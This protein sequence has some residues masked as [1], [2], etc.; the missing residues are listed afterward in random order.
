MAV[1][2]FHTLIARNKRNSFFLIAL[3]MLFFVGMG[4]LIGYVWGRD[5]LFGSVVAGIA[6]AVA[7][8]LTITSYF[9]GS[10]ALLGLSPGEAFRRPGGAGSRQSGHSATLHRPPDKKLREASGRDLQ[11]APERAGPDQTPDVAGD[12]TGQK[13]P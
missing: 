13:L 1:E 3:F 10:S 4:M 6:G 7:F 12:M 2:T 11:H 5:L 8:L 9:G